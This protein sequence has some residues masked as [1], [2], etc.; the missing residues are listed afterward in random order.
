MRKLPSTSGKE[1]EAPRTEETESRVVSHEEITVFEEL[2]RSVIE[3]DHPQASQDSES[4]EPKEHRSDS[5]EILTVTEEVAHSPRVVLVAHPI[6]STA[7]LIRETLEQFTGAKVYATGDPIR[8]FELA[9]QHRCVLF[10]LAMRIGEL[11]G[12]M[13]YELV[14]R[15]CATGRGPYRHVPGV[16]FVR[17]RDDPRLPDSLARDVRVK[18][19]LGKPISIERILNTVEGILE[20]HDPTLRDDTV[21]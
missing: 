17:E 7:R 5:D 11:S 16:V 14:S 13:L 19:V 12:P 4:P 18:D 8:A 20:V 9:L 3:S 1:I 10:F 2:E 6:P 21:G 15:A